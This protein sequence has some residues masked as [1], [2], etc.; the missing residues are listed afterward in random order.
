MLRYALLA[1]ATLAIALLAVPPAADSRLTAGLICS[2]VYNPAVQT[3]LY[4]VGVA[5]PDTLNA[6]RGDVVPRVNGQGVDGRSTNRAVYGQLIKVIR[7]SASGSSELQAALARVNNEVL[8]VPWTYDSVCVT[9]YWTR[10]A[11][12]SQPSEEAFYAPRLRPTNLWVQDR[13]TFD[14]LMLDPSPYPYGKLYRPGFRGSQPITDSIFLSADEY[15]SLHSALPT[16][17]ELKNA[18]RTAF[19]RLREWEVMNPGLTGRYPAAEILAA[20]KR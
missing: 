7:I 4:F 14:A 18:P 17:T 20:S 8:V 12:W 9:T 19:N 10:S 3:P 1:P 2:L 13:P 5:T 6:G 11:R 15:F 16:P